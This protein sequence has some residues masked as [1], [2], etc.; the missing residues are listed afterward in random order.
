MVNQHDSNMHF[1]D[2]EEMNQ[3]RLELNNKKYIGVSHIYRN[4]YII[5]SLFNLSIF[6]L[7]FT[8]NPTWNV[9]PN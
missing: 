5:Y 2:N 9:D 8:F 6:E 7:L 1:G 3:Q 4:I